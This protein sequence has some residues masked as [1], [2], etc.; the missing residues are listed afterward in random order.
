VVSTQHE[1][2][3]NSFVYAVKN[4]TVAATRKSRI[5]CPSRKPDPDPD[6][7]PDPELE[8]GQSQSQSLGQG[9]NVLNPHS[10]TL[11]QNE[12]TLETQEDD[13]NDDE[14]SDAELYRTS[15]L[16]LEIEIKLTQYLKL[17]VMERETNIYHY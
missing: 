5:A 15:P 12:N 11:Q 14:L 16:E 1:F 8:P 3:I 7:D 9:R 2:T 17:P 10:Q 13:D 6:P 4:I